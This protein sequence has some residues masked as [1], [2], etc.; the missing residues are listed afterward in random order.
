[1][2]LGRNVVPI[3]TRWRGTVA[4]VVSLRAKSVSLF[5]PDKHMEAKSWRRTVRESEHGE[6]EDKSRELVRI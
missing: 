6:S 2:V 1:M 5:V 4:N 3:A